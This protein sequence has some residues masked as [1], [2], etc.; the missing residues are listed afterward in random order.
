MTLTLLGVSK[1]F[2]FVHYKLLIPIAEHVSISQSA[3]QLFKGKFFHRLQTVNSDD[4]SSVYG[5][6]AYGFP[7]DYVL[8]PIPF[9]IYSSAITK[10]IKFCS[11]HS[12]AGFILFFLRLQI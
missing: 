11:S 4:N 6:S 1:A 9:T 12:Y 5:G 2:D 7:Q 3:L 8:G 10:T